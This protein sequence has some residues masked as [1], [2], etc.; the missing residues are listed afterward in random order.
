MLVC[1][2]TA[3]APAPVP[4]P[5]ATAAAAPTAVAH[6]P[7]IRFAL[8]GKLTNAN[9]WSLFDSSGYSYNDYA[10][11]S[12]HWP[13]L[14]DLSIPDGRFEAR[15]ASGDPS[16]VRQEGTLFI[17]TVGLRTDLK[18]SDG[19]PLTAEDVAF[20]VNTALAF[21]LRF[22]WADYYNSAWLDH[23]EAQDAHT[24]KFFFK[25]MPNVGVWQ[26]GA[27]QGPIVQS[28]YWSTQVAGA[29]S[30]LPPAALIGQIESLKTQV[31]S[32]EAQLGLLNYSAAT[33]QGEGAR[34]VQ[35][36]LKRQQGDLDKAIND[37][38]KAQG[39]YDSALSAARTAL[40]AL[41]DQGEPQL[42]AWIA[43]PASSSQEAQ[44][45]NEPNPTYSGAQ[46]H[47]D[48]AVYQLFPT[49]DAAMAALKAGQVNVVLDPSGAE[50][51]GSM[52]SPTRS[53]RFLV[54]NL[55]S[56]TWKSQALRMALACM[57]DQSELARTLGSQAIALTSFVPE[58]ESTWFLP[59][60]G[61][62]CVGMNPTARLAQ[63]VG[64][65]KGDGFTWAQE[66]S[67]ASAGEGLSSADGQSVPAFTLIVPSNDDLRAAAGDYV[68]QQARQLGI[69]LTVQRVPSDSVNFA[70]FSSHSYDMAI[71]GWSVS[72]FP[73]Y[74]CEWFGRG[75]PFEYSGSLVLSPCDELKAA[76]SLETA[77]QLVSDLQ[78]SLAQDLPFIPLFSAAV[79]DSPV[80]V[81]YPFSEI[82]GGL[83]AV[84]GAPDLAVPI[85][86]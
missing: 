55:Q 82:L 19:S 58:Q 5:T 36:G 4:S 49:P 11:R 46:P 65:M 45:S 17:A 61:V 20:T 66:P 50:S 68:A 83:A 71:L 15:A 37:L 60:S 57:L 54:F 81:R 70:V 33:S 42:G 29:S 1:L 48:R 14:Y 9:V 43:V 72:H 34:Q 84:Y 63:A 16:P 80:K 73:G 18:W 22:D 69:E 59:N 31:A 2:L 44:F 52:K 10:V 32:L 74:L 77:S 27:L 13:R 62:L 28:K 21:Q 30:L 8:I 76:S 24:V 75:R 40:F 67:A 23:A 7:E 12:G 85:L 6:A 47:F 79:Y 51:T 56:P 64:Q 26:Y 78:S 86:P 38:A 25:Q 53:M 3:C 41:S 39:D 35:S